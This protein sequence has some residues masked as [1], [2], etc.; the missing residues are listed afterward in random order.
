M[1]FCLGA[2]V[3]AD[4]VSAPEWVP[5]VDQVLLMASIFLTYSAGVIPGGKPLSDARRSTS[6]DF[7]VPKN[8]SLS[9]R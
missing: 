4:F 8:S 7:T 6:N 3:N 5:Y 2:L 1:C 9:G